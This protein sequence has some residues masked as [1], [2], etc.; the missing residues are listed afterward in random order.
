MERLAIAPFE[1]LSSD[2]KL[3]WAGRTIASA[4]VYDLAPAGDL[5]AEPVDSVSG[6]FT[7]QASRLLE[8]YY[9]ERN[10]QLTLTANL[11]NL[12]KTK[13]LASFQ[14]SGPVSEG[15][16]PLVNQLAKRLSP[17]AR[18]FGTGN[19]EAFRAYASAVGGRRIR[20]H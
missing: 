19:L 3:D 17:S 6:A 7:S 1:N 13:T 8:G 20:E 2:S 18:P 16:L 11:A 5:F 12:A 9:S 15:L 14:L 10:G 4:L